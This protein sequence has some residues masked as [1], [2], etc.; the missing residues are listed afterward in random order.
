[1]AALTLTQKANMATSLSFQL[2]MAA[3]VKAKAKTIIDAIP[4]T[5]AN[6]NIENK[7]R[8]VFARAIFSSGS[9][10]NPQAYAEYFLSQYNDVNPT[11][12]E[13]LEVADVHLTNH[14]AVTATFD[15]FAGVETGD[16]I[17]QI[18]L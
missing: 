5:F 10:P 3:A 18:I 8:K 6:Y 15:Y 17:K 11:L 12:D 16:T 1:M 13:N 9:I 7:K 2:R 14:P 4:T